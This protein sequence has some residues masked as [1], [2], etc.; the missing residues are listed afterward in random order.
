MSIKQITLIGLVFSL[1]IGCS[2]NKTITTNVSNNSSTDVKTTE[3]LS[4]GEKLT[5]NNH[6]PIT[7]R[8]A[9]YH[10]LKNEQLDKYNFEDEKEL[11]TYAY[12]LLNT[13]FQEEAIE[14]FKLNI[15]QFPTSGDAHY[16]LA[17]GYSNLSYKYRELAKA[18]REK[19]NEIWSVLEMDETWGTEIFHFP[20]RSAKGINYEGIEDA[21]FPKG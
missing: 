11:N 2:T 4:I 13:N 20:I 1:F 19:A 12:S 9:L 16:N 21:R 5:E 6:L 8:I 10:Q 7:E 15:E 17:D 14:I 18:N 3:K